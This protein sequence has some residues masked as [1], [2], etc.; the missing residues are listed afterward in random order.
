MVFTIEVILGEWKAINIIPVAIAS[1]AGAQIS[2]I[3]QGNQIAFEH[4][5]FHIDLLDITACFGLALL[6]ALASILLTR[7]LRGSA[8]L[9]GS[10]QI[11]LWARAAA[12]VPWAAS[13][14]CCRQ[15]L[16]KDITLSGR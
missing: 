4:R 8:R 6:C 2:R 10:W 16:G 13:A 15:F 14:S 3:L 5:L 1:V 9:S 12:D 11:P 7:L